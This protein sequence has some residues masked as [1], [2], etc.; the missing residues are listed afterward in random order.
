MKYARYFSRRRT[1]WLT[2]AFLIRFIIYLMIIM[3][4]YIIEHIAN[5]EPLP[6]I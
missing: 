5:G 4:D 2:E 3:G 1:C 6:L